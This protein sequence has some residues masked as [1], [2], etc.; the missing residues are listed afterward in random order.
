MTNFFIP[1]V[2]TQRHIKAFIPAFQKTGKTVFSLSAAEILRKLEDEKTGNKTK[3]AMIASESPHDYSEE[4]EFEVFVTTSIN[5]ANAAI[6]QACE[7]EEYSVIIID[8]ATEY[9]K[10]LIEVWTAYVYDHGSDKQKKDIATDNVSYYDRRFYNKPWVQFVRNIVEGKKHIL[11]TSRKTDTY[12]KV[13]GNIEKDGDRAQVHSKFEYEFSHIFELNRTPDGKY[14][15]DYT[16][17][18]KKYDGIVDLPDFKGEKSTYLSE[19]YGKFEGIFKS[20]GTYVGSVDSGESLKKDSDVLKVNKENDT[21]SEGL[22]MVIQE[23]SEFVK[24]KHI[25]EMQNYQKYFKKSFSMDLPEVVLSSDAGSKVKII[26]KLKKDFLKK[27]PEDKTE[28]M[29]ILGE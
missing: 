17:R 22:G 6:I 3:I 27:W 29:K 16:G 4:F 26:N 1:A 8:S 19:F 28:I 10:N 20:I 25:D 21:N 12:K 7:S 13:D 18:N 11:V 14:F 9:Y 15:A 23:F 24:M 2:S 5:E